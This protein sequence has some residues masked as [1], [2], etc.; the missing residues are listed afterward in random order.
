MELAVEPSKITAFYIAYNRNNAE[1]KGQRGATFG[2][3]GQNIMGFSGGALILLV[4][5]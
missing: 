4:K 3:V 1:K 2:S 5:T